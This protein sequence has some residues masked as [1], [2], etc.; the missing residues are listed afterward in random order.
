MKGAHKANLEA[1]EIKKPVKKKL[2]AKKAKVTAKK[3]AVAKE[4]KASP[5][6]TKPAKKINCQLPGAEM[7]KEG[8]CVKEIMD[9]LKKDLTP[10]QDRFCREYIRDDNGTRAYQRSYPNSSYESARRDASRLLTNADI[11]K[12]I[13]ELREARNKR[14]ELS[15]DKVLRRLEARANF[16]PADLYDSN[17]VMLAIHELD[18]DVAIGIKSIEVVEFYEGRGDQKQATGL[19]KKITCFDGKASDELLGR[20]LKL[21]KD[22]G[23]SENPAVFEKIERTI[24]KPKHD[25]A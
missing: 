17:G 21:W 4:P 22:V 8:K 19:I 18:P 1:I 16:N 6:P 14:L 20:N 7:L 24:V 9:K 13:E 12:R 11:N 5:A 25:D 10:A 2:P 15:A 3:K 23:S